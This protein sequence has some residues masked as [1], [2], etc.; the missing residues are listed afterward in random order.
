ME[1]RTKLDFSSNRQIKQYPETITVLSGATSFG[2]PFSAL[3]TGP[4][5]T[6]TG[7]TNTINGVV[8]TFSGNSTVSVYAWYDASM[9]L[10]RNTLSAWTPSNSGI[11]QNTGVVFTSNTRTTIDGNTVATSYSGLSFDLLPISFISLGGGRY[12][13]TVY[14]DILTYYSAGTLDFT[15]RTIWVDVSGITRT[16]RLI[17][18]DVGAGPSLI[19]IGVNGSGF[20][21]NQVSDIQ[22]KE[23]INQIE[24]A[25][26]KVKSLRGVTYNWKDR[27]NG[28]DELKIGFIAQEVELAVPELTY[29]TKEYKGVH[30]KD[31]TALLVEAIKEMS[32][33]ITNNM[34]FTQTVVAEDNNIEL[35]YNGTTESA[36]G[37]GLVVI[38]GI[39]DGKHSQIILNDK[40]NWVT[41]NSFIPKSLII[42][43]RTP[44]SSTD[45]YGIEGEMTRDDNYLYIKITSNEENLWGRIE[46]DTNF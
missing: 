39:S 33:G 5:L 2:V 21:V 12:S 25:L 37:G 23:N 42:P 35:N 1:Y 16:N 13:G 15:G 27:E 30:Y 41:N 45:S 9:N 14:T 10:C 40:G 44:D 43:K 22:L 20:V 3:T 19:D 8:S 26:D 4:N 36:I 6:T 28:G 46:L 17:I 11:T 32:T 24:N 7:V 38:N 34:I 29:T 18:T 31:I